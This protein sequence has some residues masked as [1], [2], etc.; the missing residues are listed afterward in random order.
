MTALRLLGL[1]VILNV[2]RY[3]GGFVVMPLITTHLF[4][5]MEE[6]PTVFNLQYGTADWV[7]SFGYNFLLWLAC[8]WAYHLMRASL[9]GGEVMR[10]FKA[11]GLMWLFFAALSA[12]YMN[13]YLH[14]KVF[15]LASI[16]DGFFAFAVVA[17]ANGM[18]YPMVMGVPRAQ[19]EPVS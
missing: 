7:T 11:F 8:T 18:L 10:S 13:H 1:V 4:V 19:A 6:N 15:Y 14:S 2:A 16:G 5:V 3:V 9:A 17:F 12:V